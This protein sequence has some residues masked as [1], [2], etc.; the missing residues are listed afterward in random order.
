M[1]VTPQFFGRKQLEEWLASKGKTYKR[2]P[3]MLLQNQPV[4]LSW[5]NVKEQ[6]KREKAEKT[7][8]PEQLSLEKIDAM[9][10]ECL[11]LA[12]EVGMEKEVL[13]QDCEPP[14]QPGH[15]NRLRVPLA[16]AARVV[17]RGAGEGKALEMGVGQRQAARGKRCNASSWGLRLPLAVP[18]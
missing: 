1:T 8:K 3:M 17:T 10:T 12:E 11:K 13:E 9:L 5:R 14:Q 18:W 6:V 2:P 7:E 16:A 4:K 15:W